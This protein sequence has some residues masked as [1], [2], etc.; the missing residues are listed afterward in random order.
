[1]ARA[2]LEQ[3]APGGP[4]RMTEP[5]AVALNRDRLLSGGATGDGLMSRQEDAFRGCLNPHGPGDVIEQ[6]EAQSPTAYLLVAHHGLLELFPAPLPFGEAGRQ[7]DRIEALTVQGERVS[8]QIAVAVGDLGGEDAADGDRLS[9]TPGVPG[10]LL[11]RVGVGV[12]VVE[13]LPQAGLGEIPPP[14]RRP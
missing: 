6:D 14:P 11:D 10:D 1:M 13:D 4:M 3:P 12:S 9:V 8:A 2:T 5:G 7:I